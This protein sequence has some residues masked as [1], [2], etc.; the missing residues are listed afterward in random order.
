[1]ADTDVDRIADWSLAAV[2]LVVI[3]IIRSVAS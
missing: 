2:A 3:V 1:M